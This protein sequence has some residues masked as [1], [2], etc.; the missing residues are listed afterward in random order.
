MGYV[1]KLDG[2]EWKKREPGETTKDEDIVSGEETFIVGNEFAFV[3]LRKVHTRNGERLEIE[4]P[5][6]GHTIRLDA[7]ELE[8]LTWQ[9]PET[10]SA[11]L[12]T[13]FGPDPEH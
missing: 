11:F 3:K 4:S 8:S 13:P 9:T 2:E 12:E 7:M 5:R 1:A 10:F 6:A